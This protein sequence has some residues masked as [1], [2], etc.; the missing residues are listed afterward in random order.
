MSSFILYI[1]I[2]NEYSTLTIEHY[3][4]IVLLDLGSAISCKK[5]YTSWEVVAPCRSTKKVNYY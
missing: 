5:V 3:L 4:N 2:V 1:I